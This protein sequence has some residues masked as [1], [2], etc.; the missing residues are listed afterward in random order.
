MVYT[1]FNPTSNL[2]HGS[3]QKQK[4]SKIDYDL[5][6]TGKNKYWKIKCDR[7]YNV[8]PLINNFISKYIPC[9]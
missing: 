6:K 4:L 3:W 8:L 7:V 2:T 1:I 9:I 5:F